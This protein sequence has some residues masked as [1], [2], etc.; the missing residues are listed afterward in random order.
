MRHVR[1]PKNSH[2]CGQACLAILLGC[3]LSAACKLIGRTGPTNTRDLAQALRK[4]HRRVANRLTIWRKEPLPTTAILKVKIRGRKMWHWV[5][6]QK[7]TIHDPKKASPVS[8]D[9]GLWAP[10]G[11]IT[12][13][14]PVPAASKEPR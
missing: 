1:Q 9:R 2:L 14:L 13:Y 5:V 4:R 12:S 6:K 3:D 11:R 8:F 7:D 10:K